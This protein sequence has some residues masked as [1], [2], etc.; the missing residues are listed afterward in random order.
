MNKQHFIDCEGNNFFQRNNNYIENDNDIILKNININNII[1]KKILEIGCSNGWR[2][3]KL[4]EKNNSCE[5]YGI[6][7]SIDAINDG[8]KYSN[9][10][11]EVGTCDNINNLDNFFDIILI[12][13]VFMYIDRNLLIKS[14]SEIDRV[15]KNNGLL[16]ITDF[17][18]NK[19]RKNSYKYI[20]NMFIY[21]QN[22][23]NIFL[24]TQN[25]F[26]NK[27]ECFTHNTSNNNDNYDDTCFYAEL[28]KDIENL[29][30]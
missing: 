8:K 21:K 4:F 3:N 18:S 5:Y 6:D 30:S 11:L 7:P 14:I 20:E 27:L 28:S 22:Y 2:L 16:I 12:P 26:L 1:N 24:S 17:Y 25:Y 9:I 10:N 29:F 23:F 15:L 19:P 13:F